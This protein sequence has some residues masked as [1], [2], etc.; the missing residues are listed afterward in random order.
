MKDG[1]NQGS[2]VIRKAF[3]ECN[4]ILRETSCKEFFDEKEFMRISQQTA[5]SGEA[6]HDYLMNFCIKKISIGMPK[7]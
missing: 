2:F 6:F 5:R 7:S 1:K 4:K 3:F